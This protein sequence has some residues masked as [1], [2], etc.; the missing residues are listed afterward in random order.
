[1]ATLLDR[2][3]GGGL[4]GVYARV[5][6]GLVLIG[7][8]VRM[9]GFKTQIP[10][11]PV[12]AFSGR[13]GRR[14][15]RWH[16]MTP[17][18]LKVY[19]EA[20][21]EIARCAR[22]KASELF[23]GPKYRLWRD[24]DGTTIHGGSLSGRLPTLP[25]SL[26]AL[27]HLKA[28]DVIE[29]VI[30]SLP[31]EF[32]RFSK[33]RDLALAD[34]GLREIPPWF[35]E[36]ATI[37]TLSLWGNPLIGEAPDFPL[38]PDLGELF[39]GRCGLG[40][41]PSSCWAQKGLR[42]LNLYG[43]PLRHLPADIGRLERLE[44]LG[45]ED[46]GLTA[47]PRALLD[48]AKRGT[49]KTLNLR[50]NPALELPDALLGDLFEGGVALD[51][52]TAYF[53]RQRATAAHQ[54]RPFRE[55][56]VVLVGD[57][58]A[59]KSSVAKWLVHRKRADA[60]ERQQTLGVDILEWPI[61]DIPGKGP[62]MA[63]VWDF[64]G[65]E[66][67]HETH[68]K[69]FLGEEAVYLLVVNKGGDDPATKIRYWMK[70]I[71]AQ[72][73]KARVL[74]ALNHC[75]D[76][77]CHLSERDLPA[78]CRENFPEKALFPTSCTTGKGLAAL[79]KALFK[80][81]ASLREPWLPWA[82]EYFAVKEKMATLKKD[83]RAHVTL[84]Y[85]AEV[86]AKA[87]LREVG[88]RNALLACLDHAG[89]LVRIPK[90]EDDDR[91]LLEPEWLTSGLYQVLNHQELANAR[92]LLRKPELRR[93][94][95]ETR[96]SAADCAWLLK[97][98]EAHELAFESGGAWFVPP[99]LSQSPDDNAEA[100]LAALAPSRPALRLICRYSETLP[101]GVIGRL[102]AKTHDLSPRQLWWRDGIV[103]EST[104]PAPF[105]AFVQARWDEIR[106]GQGDI[107]ITVAG[108]G[109]GP[110]KLLAVLRRYLDEIHH[111]YRDLDPELL[112][113]HPDFPDAPPIPLVELEEAERK[114]LKKY[115]R[116]MGKHGFQEIVVADLLG[117]LART[118]PPDWG[119]DSY[120]DT[121]DVVPPKPP[122]VFLS[123]LGEDVDAIVE[124]REA[125]KKEG[126]QVWWDK[127][128]IPN[129]TA[130]R[131]KVR[132]AVLKANAVVSCWS[133]S[134]DER[135]RTVAKFEVETAVPKHQDMLN[136]NAFIFP[137]R[138]EE[139]EIPLIV[140]GNDRLEDLRISNL[141]GPKRAGALKK[142]VADLVRAMKRR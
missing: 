59:G 29:A 7:R 100:A 114:D 111:S 70:L 37:R 53:D 113:P 88:G 72:A 103:L 58:M 120:M 55:A 136:G 119:E 48:L 104:S 39:L 9:A 133:H 129:G 13:P 123:Y 42:S 99:L 45:L 14:E 6:R 85:Y 134:V 95:D 43:N 30:P 108:A 106:G 126:L 122:Y 38:P 35:E 130:W 27:T 105:E 117:P 98:M 64:G 63:R 96:Y 142:L 87:G 138:L 54:A 121:D 124:L 40:A 86:C 28:L 76:G 56:R 68:Q 52:L 41:V 4:E 110:I 94:L 57:G 112:V 101:V 36:I 20:E 8:G 33:L 26:F 93:W 15:I 67:M 83:G 44:H 140:V 17:D 71:R 34:V 92:G 12:P 132:D 46:C 78:E 127:L 3:P 24:D 22:E 84:E 49:L 50:G 21:R 1:M 80:E 69:L 81:L 60:S 73:P 97:V 118:N 77:T 19:R 135:D 90:V 115:P 31:E 79:E 102:I 18:E 25:K 107:S 75:D 23:L 137:V 51:I 47:L 2:K 109:L 82:P 11:G 74:V 89:L 116:H 66:L 62:L 125:L 61:P 131:P 128:H 32:R 91:A 141:F 16:N 5:E 10:I 139:C 65:Q